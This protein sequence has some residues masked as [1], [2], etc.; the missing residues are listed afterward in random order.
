MECFIIILDVL[1]R[2]RLSGDRVCDTPKGERCPQK[3]GM[4]SEGLGAPKPHLP[5]VSQVLFM[6]M[7]KDGS[8]DFQNKSQLSELLED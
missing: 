6:I 7:I 1:P 4:Q 8:K 5:Q 2:S 3:G